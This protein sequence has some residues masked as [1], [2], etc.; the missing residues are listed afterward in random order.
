M[1]NV[2]IYAQY[3]IA[4]TRK[5]LIG[6]M[7]KL[8]TIFEADISEE[9]NRKSVETMLANFDY[10]MKE[11]YKRK[12]INEAASKQREYEVNDIQKYT[13]D[14]IKDII[15]SRINRMFLNYNKQ[16]DDILNYHD[17]KIF[18]ILDY[19]DFLGDNLNRYYSESPISQFGMWL[20]NVLH[21]DF[22]IS[23]YNRSK[24]ISDASFRNMLDKKRFENFLGSSYAFA[25]DDYDHYV[26]HKNYLKTK[27]CDFIPGMNVGIAL[28]DSSLYVKLNDIKVDIYSPTIDDVGIQKSEDSSLY[29]YETRNRI[30]LDF[31]EKELREYIHDECKIV[32]IRLN[33]SVGIRNTENNESALL[34]TRTNEE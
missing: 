34:I 8:H 11:E 12:V 20:A 26:E 16:C 13:E 9:K 24:D 7:M 2:D 22:N 14:K 17:V 6:Q 5:N 30:A 4:V 31:N 10:V 1:L 29:T 33:V 32:D 18:S 21:R 3:L 15:E 28:I 27:A 25:C 19:T 23:I